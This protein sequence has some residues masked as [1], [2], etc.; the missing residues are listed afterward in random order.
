M[1]PVAAYDRIAPVFARLAKRR[2]A[3]LDRVDQLVLSEIALGSRS[4]L[5]VGSGDGA[6]ARRIARSPGITELVLLEPSLAM[7][8]KDLVDAKV[9]TM[10]AEEL[11]SVQ[12]EFDVITCLWN[13]LGHILPSASR[14]GVLRQFAR[15]VSPRG[16]IFVDVNHRYNA[17]H[18]GSL[19]TALRFLRDRAS[20]DERNGDVTVTW[21]VEETRCTTQ[22][23]VFTD[24]EFRA[25]SRAAGLT[26]EK[27]FVVDYA[28]GE[29]RRRGWEGN[30]LYVL[31][32]A[33][34][35]AA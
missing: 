21:D 35:D 4:L 6:R 12:A 33:A 17:R 7:Q 34:A 10:R 13:V 14:I 8:G 9:W 1:D 28:T 5:D 18:Y 32:P 11:H 23:H 3:Y 27:T 29:L 2:R 19:Q 30:L 16:K 22:G 24:K 20:W 15:L 25:L 31:G 26:I